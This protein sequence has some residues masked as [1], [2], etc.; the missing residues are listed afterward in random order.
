MTNTWV[1]QPERGNNFIFRLGTWGILTFGRKFSFICSYFFTAY[2]FLTSPVQRKIATASLTRILGR[3]P[4]WY[5]VFR[6][7]H[8]FGLSILDRVYFITGNLKPLHIIVHSG[9]LLDDYIEQKQ[10]LLLLGSHLGCFEIARSVGLNARKPAPI[11]ALMY[12]HISGVM[13]KV[14]DDLNGNIQDTIIE[15]QDIDSLLQVQ[16]ALEKGY[17]VGILGDRV[18]SEHR[19]Q[20]LSFLEKTAYFPEQPFLISYLCQKPVLLFF[21]VYVGGNRYEV[22]LES[23]MITNDCHTLTKEEYVKKG[24]E[25]YIA[26]LEYYTK[27]FPYNWFNFFDFWAPT[28]TSNPSK[29]KSNNA[30]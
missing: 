4:R 14:I 3:T 26:R 22:F 13:N 17:I 8:A 11:K 12:T 23:L 20:A 2:F 1:K 30:I 7:Y 25:N 5:E 15:A 9:H 19:A 16:H 24:L 28:V 6:N 18:I 27:K 10:G 29:M 21:S